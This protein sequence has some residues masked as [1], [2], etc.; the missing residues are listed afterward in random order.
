[1]P[2][3]AIDPS[4]V[5]AKKEAPKATISSGV[6]FTD[7]LA[8][9][10]PGTT[11]AV[12]VANR[13][14]PAYAYQASTATQAAMS[15]AAGLPSALSTNAG[16]APY[17][18]SVLGINT[19]YNYAGVPS[20][21]GYAGGTGLTGAYGAPGTTA[22]AAGGVGSEAQ[23]RAQFMQV[24]SNQNWQMLQDQINVNRITTAYTAASNIEQSNNTA[25]K[26]AIG[27]MRA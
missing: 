6:D 8:A 25:K 21:S 4:R 12:G 11:A 26:N 23:D 15:T 19:G 5:S 18:T 7:V 3:T 2:I 27:N 17:S 16:N 13:G 9:A 10:T 22:A 1:M 24:M 20:G 14:N